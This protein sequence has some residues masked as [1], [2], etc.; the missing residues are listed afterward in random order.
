MGKLVDTIGICLHAGKAIADNNPR[1]A[2][3]ALLIINNTIE[4]SGLSNRGAVNNNTLLRL[5]LLAV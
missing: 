2:L 4:C 3:T 5:L 1:N